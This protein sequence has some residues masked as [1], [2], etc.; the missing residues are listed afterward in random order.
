RYRGLL[1]VHAPPLPRPRRPTG[2]R[3]ARARR[4]RRPAAPPRVRTLRLADALRR[5]ARRRAGR[6]CGGVLRP[7]HRA[8]DLPRALGRGDPR[9]G[10]A[11]GAP[12]SRRRAAPAPP[13][14]TAPHT[15]PARRARA[16]ARPRTHR[17]QTR[18]CR[19]RDP[20]PRTVAPDRR[21][22][23]RDDRRPAAGRLAP[24]ARDRTRLRTRPPQS[25]DRNM[26]TLDEHL[27]HAPPEIC[28][29]IAA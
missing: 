14:R 6:R 24:P 27:M 3:D 7:L 16:P 29:R 1:L 21:S 20:P 9:G 2:R 8:G 23:D 25:G 11:P 4:E 15:I 26:M 28:F 10:A 17:L 19:F 5:R 12:P 13:L 22:A 18:P